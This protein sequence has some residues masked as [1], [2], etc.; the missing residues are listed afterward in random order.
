LVVEEGWR[1]SEV[2]R[3][4]GIS[5]GLLRC[6]KQK[7]EEGK[8]EPFPGRGRL[9]PENDAFRKLKREN[10]RLRM[11]RDILKKAMAI[12]SEEPQ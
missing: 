4:L 1:V 8:V 6:W 10:A 7:Y 5:E 9:S 2:S 11:E 12:F 3:E